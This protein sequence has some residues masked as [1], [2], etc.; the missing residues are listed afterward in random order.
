MISWPQLAVHFGNEGNNIR[1]FRQTIRDAW[2]RQ[3]SAVY[4]EARA[5]FDT[6]AVRLYAS[7]APLARRP[8]RLVTGTALAEPVQIATT[9][10]RAV[11][12]DFLT[13][14]RE[15]LGATHA[16]HWLDD[17]AMEDQPD[18]PAALGAGS[19]F[20]ADYIRRTFM[21]EIN[22]AASACRLDA[23]PNIVARRRPLP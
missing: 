15:I 8:L 21:L 12:P 18:G 13:T 7:P 19:K 6:T 22:R 17:A 3:V 20:K 5:E 10:N 14:L 9:N 16:K 23:S 1:K 2:E 11:L 4:P